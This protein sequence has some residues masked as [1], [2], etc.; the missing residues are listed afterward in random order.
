MAV[1]LIRAGSHGEYE[2]KFIQE[3]RVYVTWEGFDKDL[4]QL[5]GRNELTKALNA[6]YPGEKPRKIVNWTS[7]IWPFVHEIKRGDI[8]V[9]PQKLQRTI[10]I[11]EVVGDYQFDSTG[12]DPFYHWREVKWIGE[13]IPRSNFG[14]D[15][16]NSFGAFMTI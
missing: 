7:Q 10:Q 11:G 12:P 2:Q 14:Q 1:W 5:K 3:K 9:L 6:C 4:G 15:L 8:I 13:S 16:L